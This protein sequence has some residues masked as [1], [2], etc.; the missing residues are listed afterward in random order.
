MPSQRKP[1]PFAPHSHFT[2]AK[3]LTRAQAV[4]A[5]PKPRKDARALTYDPKTGKG[6]WV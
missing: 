2:I 5:A 4:K 1:A 6:Y 3:G